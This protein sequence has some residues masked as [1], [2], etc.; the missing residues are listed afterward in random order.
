MHSAPPPP[1]SP[2]IPTQR[3]FPPVWQADARIL[4]LGSFPGT[5]SLA[6]HAYYAHPRNQFWPIVG[7]LIDVPLADLPYP[8]RLEQLRAHRIALW[9][10]LGHCRR[11]GSLDSKIQ[12]AILNEFQPLLN[13]LPELKLIGFN[14]QRAAR[15]RAT[16]ES[17]GYQTAVLPSTSPAHASLSLADKREHWLSALRP[18]L[19]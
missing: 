19:A 6:A 15:Q 16:F 8:E 11:E 18:W 12:D 4:L 1:T 3:G 14:G 17:L 13:Q 9:D 5:A 10:T 2:I 7:S